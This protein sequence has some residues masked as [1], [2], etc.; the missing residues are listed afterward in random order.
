MPWAEFAPAIPK[1]ERLRGLGP[2]TARPL[3]PELGLNMF[4]YMVAE[5]SKTLARRSKE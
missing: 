4:V 5:F 2:E 3:R 1:N